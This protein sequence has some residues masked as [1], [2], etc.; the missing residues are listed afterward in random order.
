MFFKCSLLTQKKIEKF[1]AN[2]RALLSLKLFCCVFFISLFAEFIAN[3]N[4]LLVRYDGQFYF[5]TLVSYPETT[6]GGTFQTQ[7]NYQDE[8]VIDLIQQ[9]GW[10]LRPPIHF[11]SNTI[12]YDLMEPAPSFPDSE[13][14]LGT[15]DQGRDLLA[16]LIYGFRL[17]ILFALS[18]TF[19]SVIIGIS[20]GAVQGYFGGKVDLILQRL[21]E[22][23]SGLPILYLLIILS[24]M[25][26]P[27]VFWLLF[28]MMLF[29][30]VTIVNVVRVEFF[31][32]RSLDYVR[33]AEALGVTNMRIIWRHILP[34]AFVSAVTYIPFLLNSSI[35]LLTSLDFLGFGLPPGSPSLG[36]IITQ[37]KNNIHAPWI[38]ITIFL[39]LAFLLTLLI[40]IG[41]GV[42]D[43]L[44]SRKNK[45]IWCE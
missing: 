5:P 1:K 45:T 25:I 42:R 43:S 28:I 13:N 23:W 26:E 41:E 37:A 22:I 29:S 14:W 9:K 8:V 7:A 35:A 4:P 21:I 27:N 3:E 19:G 36:E 17:S 40:F 11:S 32:T 24:S 33:A 18:L 44:D 15:D 38:G 31:R 12:N 30:W 16:R 10:M 39:S 2:K 6:F 20:L 34:N